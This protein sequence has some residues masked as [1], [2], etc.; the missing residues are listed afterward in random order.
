[1]NGVRTK[2]RGIKEGAEEMSQVGQVGMG[3]L[4]RCERFT[5]RLRVSCRER[6]RTLEEV[7]NVDALG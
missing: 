4:A 2:C 7:R 5:R 3:L 1:M 6:M